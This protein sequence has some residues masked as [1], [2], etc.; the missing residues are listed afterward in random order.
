MTSC[1]S[2]VV[3]ISHYSVPLNC[4]YQDS[5]YVRYRVYFVNGVRQLTF[6]SKIFV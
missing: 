3:K 6:D 4:N 1:C 2:E 5:M